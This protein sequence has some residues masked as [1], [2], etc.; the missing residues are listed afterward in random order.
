MTTANRNGQQS[1]E[2]SINNK[3]YYNIHVCTPVLNTIYDTIHS[4]KDSNGYKKV[5]IKII[6]ILNIFIMRA[7]SKTRME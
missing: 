6:K 1:L 3:V 2:F 7:Q 4:Y 5:L